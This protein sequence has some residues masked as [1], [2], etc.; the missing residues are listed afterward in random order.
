MPATALPDAPAN[1]PAPKRA[2]AAPRPPLGYDP[3]DFPRAL[4][5]HY[6]P[7]SEADLSAMLQAIGVKRLDDLFSHLPPPIRM[8]PPSP[9]RRSYPTTHY[10]TAWPPQPPATTPLPHS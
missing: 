6:I 7:A 3:A 8:T 9:S 1:S 10:K 2:A 4:A 5:R